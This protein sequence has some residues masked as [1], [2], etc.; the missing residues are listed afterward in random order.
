MLYKHNYYEATRQHHL[1]LAG[2]EF[3]SIL[4]AMNRQAELARLV[5]W[6]GRKRL[7]GPCRAYQ[8]RLGDEERRVVR[9]T[10]SSPRLAAW[11]RRLQRLNRLISPAP[12]YLAPG[13]AA[14]YSAKRLTYS[15][16]IL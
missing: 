10:L 13:S 12:R 14:I 6:A 8:A 9:Y 11:A 16:K 1:W 4:Q 15:R 3:W 7:A 5:E 2:R